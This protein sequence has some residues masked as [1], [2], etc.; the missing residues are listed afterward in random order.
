MER[1]LMKQKSS[2]NKRYL[3]Q[4][5]V[6]YELKAIGYIRAWLNLGELSVWINNIVQ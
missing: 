2:L 6:V 4:K 5:N 1:I 3:V